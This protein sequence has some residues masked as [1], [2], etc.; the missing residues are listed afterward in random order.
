MTLKEAVALRHSVRSYQQKPLD[1]A[2]RAQLEEYV[3]QINDESGLHIQLVC[4]EPKAFSSFLAHYGKFS[5]VSNYL[6]L[7]GEKSD[8][9]EEKCGYYGE[10]IV[11]YA[12]TLG[13][14]T[15]WVALTYKKIKSAYVVGKGEKLALV[16]ALGYGNTQGAVH[17]V[18]RYEEV[19]NIEQSSP[20][21]FR[22][23]VKFAL[24]APTAINQQKFFFELKEGKVKLTCRTNVCRGVD[25]G[26]VKL[27]FELGAGTENFAWAD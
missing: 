14:N 23:G 10:K 26:I 5:G 11:L 16:I 13:L 4:D 2:V 15:C 9:L 8:D 24:L 18:K 22:E 17:K 7:V 1:E 20:D 12:Q 27:H 25:L 19:S 6:A 21:W 3:R